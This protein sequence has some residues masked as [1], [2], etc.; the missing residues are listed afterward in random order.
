MKVFFCVL[1]SLLLAQAAVVKREAEAEADADALL[2]L[3]YHGV[4]PVAHVAPVV[5][6]AP[7]CETTEETVTVKQCTPKIDNN[8]NDIEIPIQTVEFEEECHD[9]TTKICT[10]K[11]VEATGGEEAAE[12]VK[13]EA[14]ADAEAD[15]GLVLPYHAAVVP[16]VHHVVAP[17]LYTT[18]CEDKVDNVCVKKP[19]VKASTKT[20]QSCQAVATVECAD[21]EH[22]VPRTTCTHAVVA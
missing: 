9:V 17:V 2:P 4:A 22:K 16:A 12:K 15:P 10:P 7:K 5:Y 20:V 14:E 8:C 11:V 18:V 19:V 13:R 21:V 6:H 1:S 3:A